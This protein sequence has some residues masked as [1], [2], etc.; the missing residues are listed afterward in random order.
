MSVEFIV[1]VILLISFAIALPWI[2][3][4]VLWNRAMRAMQKGN[5][6][7]AKSIFESRAFLLLFG[8]FSSEWNLFRIAIGEGNKKEIGKR[9]RRIVDGDFSKK[10]KIIIAKAAYFY[11][12]DQSNEEM[13]KELLSVIQESNDQKE[14]RQNE[15]LYR[16]LIEKKHED[17]EYVLQLIEEEKAKK[18]KD[19]IQ[20]GILQYILGIQYLSIGQKEMAKDVLKKAK[21]NLRN[22]P[23]SKRVKALLMN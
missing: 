4:S 7:K 11:Y 22:T 5:V 9:T 17:I 3:R 12:L 19:P 1:V 6:K 20:Y 21:Q 13:C 10:Q 16:V 2:L 8:K 18:V 14:V 15:M 23:Y